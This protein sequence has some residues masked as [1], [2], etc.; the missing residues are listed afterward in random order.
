MNDERFEKALRFTMSDAVEGGY[1]NDPD[2]HG[3]PTNFGIT[4]LV[5]DEYRRAK[6]LAYAPVKEITRQVA[7]EI[8]YERYWKRIKPELMRED[9]AIA[10]FDF[11]VNSGPTQA[12]KTL[13]D[14]L[15][16][17]SD[18]IIG[19]L[20]SRRLQ[21]T[22]STDVAYYLKARLDFV[23]SLGRKKFI[24]GWENR[25]FNLARYIGVEA[26]LVARDA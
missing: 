22:T 11:G 21:A 15:G 5:Y 12:I 6:G 25:I 4:Q 24:R 23:R 1:V 9:M 18:G 26:R 14:V 8:Y 20:T 13:Q 7:R 2:D 3:G 17:K 19:P 10:A 16:L